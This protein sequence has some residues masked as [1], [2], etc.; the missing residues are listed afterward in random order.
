MHCMQLPHP[1]RW[2]GLLLLLHICGSCLTSFQKQRVVVELSC[3]QSNGLAPEGCVNSAFPTC[4]RHSLGYSSPQE[5]HVTEVSSGLLFP[6]SCRQ[7]SIRLTYELSIVDIMTLGQKKKYFKE[8]C[9]QKKTDKRHLAPFCGRQHKDTWSWSG[10]WNLLSCL[11]RA[12]EVQVRELAGAVG[13]LLCFWCC[14]CIP[15]DWGNMQLHKEKQ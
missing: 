5:A 11:V 14:Y 7:S 6:P 8:P 13:V 9:W 2:R 12:S 3:E 4:S 15:M 1:T 10:G